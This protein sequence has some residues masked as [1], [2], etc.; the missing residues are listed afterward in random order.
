MVLD[1]NILILHLQGERYIIDT[2]ETWR[3]AGVELHISSITRAETLARSDLNNTEIEAIKEFLADFN[4]V[5]FDDHL[6]DIAA[7]IRRRIKI[8]LPDAAIAATALALETP[9]V[10]RNVRDFKS[11]PWLRIVTLS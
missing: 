2:L 11:V 1:T 6:A 4:S 5:P 3:T 9:L 10:T 8:A 7:S